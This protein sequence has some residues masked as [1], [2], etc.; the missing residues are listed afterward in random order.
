M[1][2]VLLLPSQALLLLY[3]QGKRARV[4]NKMQVC[5]LFREQFLAFDGRSST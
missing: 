5:E 2:S 1:A 4:D 3:G